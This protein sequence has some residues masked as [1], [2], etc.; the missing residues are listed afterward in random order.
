MTIRAIATFSLAAL[1]LGGCDQGEPK[2][3]SAAI[4][5]ELRQQ[6]A[7]WNQAYAKRDGAALGGFYAE[8]AV[9]ATPGERML[10]GG[11]AI[12]AASES[13]VKDPNFELAFSAERVEVADSGELAYTRGNY[14]MTI[15]DPKTKQPQKSTG[16]YLTVWEKQSDGSWKAVEDFVTPGAPPSVAQQATLL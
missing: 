4:E 3:N 16:Y 12:A 2:V 6:E 14:R 5:H 8:D 15:T 11:K 13:L 1:A 9:L 7:R 10:R